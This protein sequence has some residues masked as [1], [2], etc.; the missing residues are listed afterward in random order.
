MQPTAYNGLRWKKI[1]CNA[2]KIV[3]LHTLDY[4]GKIKNKQS[5]ALHE[6]TIHVYTIHVYTTHTQRSRM[7]QTI[8]YHA[9]KQYVQLRW[10]AVEKQTIKQSKN[11]MHFKL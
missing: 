9:F 10:A 11:P 7:K 5:N 6:Y 8:Q 4:G 2:F 1:Q 3:Q